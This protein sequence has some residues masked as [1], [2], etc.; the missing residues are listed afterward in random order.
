[1]QSSEASEL[2]KKWG[3]KPC[4]HKHIDKEYYAGSATGDYVCTQ[5]GRAEYGQDWVEKEK[6]EADMEKQLRKVEV[7][8]YGS[9]GYKPKIKNFCPFSGDNPCESSSGDSLC[10]G[11]HGMK[12]VGDK[13]YVLFGYKIDEK[14]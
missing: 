2:R 1:M 6:R 13:E 11:N 5:C 3:D 4:D 12:T 7:M 10:G 8:K 9:S 14:V